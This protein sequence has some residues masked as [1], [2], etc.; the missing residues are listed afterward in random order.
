MSLLR[1]AGWL[2]VVA[3]LAIA[4]LGPSAGS[5]LAGTFNPGQNGHPTSGH[6]TDLKGRGGDVVFKFQTNMTINC[7]GSTTQQFNMKLDYDI[8]G[9]ALPAGSTLVVYLSP[10]QGAI[11]NN[12]GGDEAGYISTVESNEGSVDMSGLS[13]SGTLTIHVSVSHPFQLSGGGVLGVIADDKDGTSAWTTKTNSINCGEA[14]ATPTPTPTEAPTPTPTEA[15]TPTPTEAPTPTPTE[16]PT[17][18]VAPTP[19]PT[20]IPTEAPTPT[21]TAIP[22][23]APTPTPTA[24][25]PAATPTPTPTGGVEAATGTPRVTLPPTDTLGGGQQGGSSSW[26]MILIVMAGVLAGILTLTPKKARR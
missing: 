1:P 2:G 20:A 15:P 24:T 5:A 6:L 25:A 11:N 18:T 17:P 7:D 21:P 4:I 8:T 19:T 9:A 14:L 3:M 12:A 10:N 13:G 23:E 26:R 22:T 16:A